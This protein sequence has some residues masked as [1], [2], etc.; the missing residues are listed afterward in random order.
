MSDETDRTIASL[1]D[2]VRSLQDALDKKQEL[3]IEYRAT[4][5]HLVE[6]E[7]GLRAEIESLK[8]LRTTR[9]EKLHREP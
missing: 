2:R 5:F 7:R 8:D 6:V 1:R 4:I 9:I 3:C